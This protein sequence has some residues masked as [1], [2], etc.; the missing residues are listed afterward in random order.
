MGGQTVAIKP[1]RKIGD[2]TF[3]AKKFNRGLIFQKF[4]D[5]EGK[6]VEYSMFSGSNASVVLPITT[7]RRVV[8]VRQFRVG[9]NEIVVELPGGCPDKKNEP[10]EKTAARELEEETGYKPGRLIRLM[11][12]KLYFDAPSSI[13]C[14]YGFLALDCQLVNEQKLDSDEKIEVFTMTLKDWMNFARNEASDLRVAAF[15]FKALPYLD[16]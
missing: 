12:E 11:P 3:L 6:E 4:I 1:W 10:P 8:A 5:D 15:L 16:L 7:D 2:P 13:N 9:A 14:I